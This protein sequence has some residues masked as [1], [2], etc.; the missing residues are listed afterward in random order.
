MTLQPEVWAG[1]SA[2]DVELPADHGRN[3]SRTTPGQPAS[4]D[5][6]EGVET[7][8]QRE[9]TNGRDQG[10]EHELG[11]HG[12][13]VAKQEH[14]GDRDEDERNRPG[15]ESAAMTAHGQ[16]G[17][18]TAQA[19][20]DEHQ[21]RG[22]HRSHVQLLAEPGQRRM[23]EST[24]RAQIAAGQSES[25]TQ[26]RRP[27]Q[28]S[29][30]ARRRATQIMCAKRE[31]VEANEDESQVGLG[32]GPGAED[33]V[34]VNP[35]GITRPSKFPAFSP[36]FPDIPIQAGPREAHQRQRYHEQCAPDEAVDPN[37][38]PGWGAFRTGGVGVKHID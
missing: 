29:P 23:K 2:G 26:R 8:Q 11:G 22:I 16:A 27:N 38:Q 20:R 18:P 31:A 24:A 6:S 13:L 30:S 4:V 33:I 15:G 1:E 35:L 25:Q 36:T 9:K 21:Q 32:V 5:F 19:H 17:N 34:D 14:T 37:G 10:A 28:I 3:E 7:V 12:P